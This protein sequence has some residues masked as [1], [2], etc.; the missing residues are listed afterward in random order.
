[1]ANYSSSAQYSETNVVPSQLYQR[2]LIPEIEN[3]VM[4]TGIVESLSL[5]QVF[6]DLQAFI[7]VQGH[8]RRS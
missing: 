2:M 1:M 8:R 7:G 3:G 4:R 5:E 6:N